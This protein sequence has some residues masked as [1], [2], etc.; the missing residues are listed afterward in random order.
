MPMTPYT[1]RVRLTCIGEICAAGKTRIDAQC[2]SCPDCTA[3]ILDLDGKVLVGFP[4]GPSAPREGH[5]QRA[6]TVAPNI[7]PEPQAAVTP[8]PKKNK[9]D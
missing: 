9:E 6:P 8:R 2:A 5:V 1:G 7:E 3:F 4:P